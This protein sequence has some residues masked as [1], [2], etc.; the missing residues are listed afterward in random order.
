MLTWTDWLKNLAIG[1]AKEKLPTLVF[2]ACRII[3]IKEFAANEKLEI[4]LSAPVQ[5][6]AGGTR[7]WGEFRP[8]SPEGTNQI[9]NVKSFVWYRR[10]RSN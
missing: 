6:K 8:P 7:V 1:P 2:R 4:V 5:R 3:K 9:G 10:P